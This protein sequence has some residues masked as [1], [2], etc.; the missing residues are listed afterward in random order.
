MDGVDDSS[1]ILERATFAGTKLA[2]SP[3]S[4]DQP[5]I[6]SV[7][8]HPLSEHLG[9]PAGVED[10]ERLT[11]TCREGGRGLDDTIFSTGGLGGVTSDEVVLSLLGSKSGDGG[12]DT[13]SVATEH[14]D[15][16]GLTVCDTGDLGIRNVLDG[17]GTSSVLGNGN[18]VVVGFTIGRIVNNIF[19][20]GAK[21]DGIE[22]LGFL[23]GP[24]Q[25]MY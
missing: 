20:D 21:L 8:L 25:R 22:D 10:N 2:S 13:K 15:V 6:D 14:N 23:Q 19:E 16:G 4:V 17:V 11:V 7:L 12:K 5:T 1:R 18:V 3:T 24:S 9:I